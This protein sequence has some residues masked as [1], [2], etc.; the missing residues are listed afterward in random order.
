MIISA[1]EARQVRDSADLV[2][3]ASD[4]EAA[5]ERLSEEITVAFGESN[6]VVMC[7]MNGALIPSGMLLL[8]CLV[9]GFLP[10]NRAAKLNPVA[11]IREE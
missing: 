10:A 2:V 3:S 7:V 9:A 4:V 11:A 8:V 6:P 5:I 1:E